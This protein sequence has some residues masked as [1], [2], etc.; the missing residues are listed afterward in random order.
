VSK[1]IPMLP[2]LYGAGSGIPDH[3][4]TEDDLLWMVDGNTGNPNRDRKIRV[5]ELRPYL[6]GTQYMASA[7]TAGSK[8]TSGV[9]TGF[10]SPYIAENIYLVRGAVY[11]V[12]VVFRHTA[13][14]NITVRVRIGA[15]SEYEYIQTSGY[16]QEASAWTYGALEHSTILERVFTP[17]V[18]AMYAD[19][20]GDDPTTQV[21]VD[22]STTL[23]YTGQTAWWFYGAHVL[24]ERIG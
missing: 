20:T 16:P 17:N 12:T 11:K 6:F 23:Q 14:I 5:A 21:T 18:G 13:G 22:E 24:F 15:H 19:G 4:L 10:G 1:T 3:A 7:V 9:P 2:S 8:P